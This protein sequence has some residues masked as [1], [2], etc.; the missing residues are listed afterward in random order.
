MKPTIILSSDPDAR[1][2][3]LE[4]IRRVIVSRPGQ[5]IWSEIQAAAQT[6][7]DIDPYLAD[8][9]F[10][11]RDTYSAELR[12]IDY[13][14]CRAVG[15][16]ILRH[17]LVY[18]IDGDRAWIDAALRQA[19]VLFDDE[20][21]PAWNHQALMDPPL[22]EVHLRTGLL[23]KDVGLMLNWLRPHL[24]QSEI[25]TLVAGLEK[26]AIRPFLDVIQ[27]NP[28]WI[29]VNNNWLTCIVGGLGVCGMALDGLHP[30]AQ[31]LIDFA[32][33]LLERHLED[34]GPEGEFNEGLGYAGAIGLAID[35]YAARL[36]WNEGLGN[37]LGESPFPEMSRWYIH[38][39]VPPGHLLSF[40]DGHMGAPLKADWMAAVAAA[41]R[42]P[43]LQDFYL[44]HRS[45]QADPL[46]ILF[47]DPDLERFS[48]DGHLP[49]GR[50]YP[51]Q[52]ACIVSRTSWDWDRTASLVGS[53]ARRE[54]NHEH[55]DPG[56]VVI[57]GEGHR[58]IVDWGTPPTTYP[59][60]FFTKDR[61]RYFDTRAFGHNVLVFGGRDLKSCYILHP[62]HTEGKLHGKRAGL[63][64]GRIVSSEFDSAWGG[65]W[66]LDTTEAWDG[67]RQC[68]R[69]VLHVFPGFVIV[70][71]EAT[72]EE[73][74]TISLR[75]NTALKPTMT[76]QDGFALQLDQVGLAARVLNLGSEPTICR[77]AIQQYQAPWNM[78]QFG[79]VLPERNCPYFE[80][81]LEGDRC[82]LLSLFA[83][84]PG[85][86][87]RAWSEKDGVHLGTIGDQRLEVIATVTG[88]CVRS[89][90]HDRHW[91]MGFI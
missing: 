37:R 65:I 44:Q 63:A 23:A 32:D 49:L 74:E 20:A 29:E 13:S 89:P 42:D 2:E 38:M 61:F 31:G 54:D 3:R 40:G 35:Y 33:P 64:Q 5:H 77:T 91:D 50:A 26:R 66:K 52:G 43:V 21:Y 83:V 79:G 57:D 68:V 90:D 78:D 9:V 73:T 48:P 11:G 15:N 67:V 1:K 70:L 56:Q 19:F 71:D 88:V 69:T 36:G 12:G 80:T 24:T 14:L 16:R 22:R 81:L 41:A 39:T 84:Q 76:G 62:K 75:W 85:N 10:P 27:T 58:L 82:R 87:T 55:N 6:E 86:Q 34:F 51:G 45:I 53:K 47:L 25:D 60:G 4:D 30:E 17:A 18:L 59:A 28:W 72:L 46:Q 8:S 7:R